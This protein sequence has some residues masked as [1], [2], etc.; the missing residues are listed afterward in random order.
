M[1]AERLEIGASAV[2][3]LDTA[4]MHSSFHKENRTPSD[5]T[6]LAHLGSHVLDA[7]ASEVLLT[8][9]VRWPL[10]RLRSYNPRIVMAEVLSGAHIEQGFDVLRL[11]TLLQTGSSVTAV[12]PPMRAGAFQ[13]VIAATF[14]S[15]ARPKELSDVLSDDLYDWLEKAVDRVAGLGRAAI[16][17]KS[18]LQEYL[19]ALRL[20]PQ[21][22]TTVSGPEHAQR[23]RATVN[24]SV[25][26]AAETFRISSDPAKRKSIAEEEAARAFMALL[27]TLLGASQWP[28]NY[29]ANPTVHRLGQALLVYASKVQPARPKSWQRINLLC[30]Q[31]FAIGDWLHVVSWAEN[32]AKLFDGCSVSFDANVLTPFVSSLSP[33][34]VAHAEQFSRAL[35]GITEFVAG[36]DPQLPAP[37]VRTTAQFRTLLALADL[38]RVSS[39]EAATQFLPEVLSDFLLIRSGRRPAVLVEGA[40]KTHA[41]FREG[42]LQCVLNR[43]L[44]SLEEHGSTEVTITFL[45]SGRKLEVTL[46]TEAANTLEHV[47]AGAQDD[48]LWPFLR[49][50]LF[51]TDV[52]VDGNSVRLVMPSVGNDGSFVSAA[53]IAYLQSCRLM[54]REEAEVVARLLHDLKNELIAYDLSLRRPQLDRTAKHRVLLDASVHLDAANTLVQSLQGIRGAMLA[55]LPTVTSPRDFLREYLLAR[56][57]TVPNNIRMEPP[58]NLAEDRVLIPVEYVRP[59]LDNLLRNSV[60]AMPKGGEVGLDWTFS[61][62]ESVLYIALWDNGPGLDAQSIERVM[63]GEGVPSQKRQGS[64]LGI[65][66]VQRMLAKL[67]GSLRV[68]SSL[69]SG[70]YWQLCIPVDSA[71]E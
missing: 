54:A 48:V 34:P 15:K 13:A 9:L 46:S 24:V 7:I 16:N 26:G 39:K 58:R 6:L 17:Q 64:G 19:Q 66:S 42:A 27:E 40:P 63:A 30:A 38:A 61:Q 44:A 62:S 69:G 5:N 45:K 43:L 68:E 31:G 55:P 52:R 21:Y 53:L 33:V 12:L 60:E 37:A 70:T 47:V 56:L 2:P 11:S 65:I 59:M 50:E 57:G 28:S 4:L 23:F 8:V 49:Q 32:V 41:V 14:L 67:N 25:P 10:E 20:I 1:L 3:L 18:R 22:A 36:L 71:G 35:S 51:I 29:W